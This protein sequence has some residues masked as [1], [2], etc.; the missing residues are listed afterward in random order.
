MGGPFTETAKN[1]KSY[2]LAEPITDKDETWQITQN[3]NQIL[4]YFIFF[5][6]R[7]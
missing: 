2:G 6:V 7:T 1:N 5:I 4:K 3:Q